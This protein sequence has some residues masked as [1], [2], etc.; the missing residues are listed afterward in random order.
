MHRIAPYV[1][2]APDNAEV[3]FIVRGGRAVWAMVYRGGFFSNAS[4]AV[5]K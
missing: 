3:H 4:Y 5:P 2:A 1:Y